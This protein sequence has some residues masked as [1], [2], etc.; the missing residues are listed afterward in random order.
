MEEKIKVKNNNNFSKIISQLNS[1]II[2]NNQLIE[3]S[4]FDTNDLY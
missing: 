1:E 4:K 3:N 2:I